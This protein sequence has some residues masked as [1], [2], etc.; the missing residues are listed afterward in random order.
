M[1][2]GEGGDGGHLRNQ[3]YH[4]APAIR[5]IVDV[6]G[7]GIEGGHRRHRADRDAH[8]V[9]VV[10]EG[11]DQ[12][13]QVLVD[14]GVNLYFALKAVQLVGRRQ[15]PPENQVGHLEEG[16]LLRQLL[17]GVAAVL[18]DAFGPVDIG[19]GA[20]R[21][22][23]VGEA[24]IIG[25]H[26]EVRIPD[27][28][29]AQIHGPDDIPLQNV[30]LVLGAGAVVGDRKSCVLRTTLFHVRPPHR[31]QMTRCT[32]FSRLS[33]TPGFASRDSASALCFRRQIV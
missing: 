33:R 10:A 21:V 28:D 3:T 24:R 25:H 5:R 27:L 16:A 22:R 1:S 4:L 8:R 18:Q 29:L 17:D 26:A 23:R 11:V 9:R 6:P 32:S 14:V 30:D 13:G 2:V 19:D 31:L 12:L 15:F 20:A 7:S